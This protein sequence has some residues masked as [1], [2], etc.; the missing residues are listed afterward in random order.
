MTTLLIE[1]QVG[2]GTMVL[3]VPAIDDS[4]R[5]QRIGKLRAMFTLMSTGYFDPPEGISTDDALDSFTVVGTEP[6]AVMVQEG[7]G[8]P[9]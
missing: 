2:T 3:E 8:D 1:A 5:Q 6:A 9:Q 4:L 7:C